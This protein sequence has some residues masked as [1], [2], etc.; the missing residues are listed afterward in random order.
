M[1]SRGESQAAIIGF[2]LS[3]SFSTRWS[4]FLDLSDLAS[5]TIPSLSASALEAM[6]FRRNWSLFLEAPKIDFSGKAD[7]W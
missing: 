5:S 6:R 4:F 7:C 3:S 2:C 1:K